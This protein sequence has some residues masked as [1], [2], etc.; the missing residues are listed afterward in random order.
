MCTSAFMFSYFIQL[1][2]HA[3]KRFVLFISE[4]GKKLFYLKLSDFPYSRTEYKLG[5]LSLLYY[6]YV[7]VPTAF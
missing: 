3:Y 7:L 6:V 1:L 5:Y 2:L 4:T